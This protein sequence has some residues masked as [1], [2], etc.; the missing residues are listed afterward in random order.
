MRVNRIRSL[1][2][3]SIGLARLPVVLPILLLIGFV[4]HIEANAN[5]RFCNNTGSRTTIAIAYVEKDAPGTSTNG[6]RGITVEGWWNIEPNECK[7]V[8]SIEAGNYWVYFYAHSSDSTWAGRSF[9]CVASRRFQSGTQFMREGD[10]CQ[11]GYR[12]QGFRRIET[13]A[14][15]HTHNL[16]N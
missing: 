12:L 10:Q 5:V 2:Q 15:N 11:T 13:A 8:S 1:I 16:T 9:L 7:V 4:F 6:H 3:S 14:K